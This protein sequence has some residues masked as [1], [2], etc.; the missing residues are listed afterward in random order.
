MFGSSEQPCA[1]QTGPGTSGVADSD[2]LATLT[3]ALNDYCATHRIV[4]EDDREQIA[5][6]IM[7]LFSRGI[8]DADEL[9]AE[10]EKAG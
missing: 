8:V 10:L 7:C 4:S 1:S 9:S 3:A 5:I 2:E 6:K